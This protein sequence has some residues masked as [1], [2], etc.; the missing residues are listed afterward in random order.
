M[1]SKSIDWFK[2]QDKANAIHVLLLREIRNIAAQKA[3]A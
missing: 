2:V 3:R 1:L